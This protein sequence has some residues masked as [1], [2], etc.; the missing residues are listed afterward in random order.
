MFLG[1]GCGTVDRVVTY[2]T[3]GRGF[4]SI[5]RQLW[6]NHKKVKRKKRG[7]ELYIKTICSIHG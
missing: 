4:E 6:L 5:H 7:P 1:S 2:D 3:R